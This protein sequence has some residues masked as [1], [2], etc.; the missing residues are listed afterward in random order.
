MSPSAAS[1]R[2]AAIGFAFSMIASAATFERVAAD[3][4][5]ARGIGAAPD[6]HLA[7]IALDEADGLERHAEPFV[8]QLGI[9]RRVSLA[10]RMRAGDDGDRAARIEAQIHALVEDAALLDVVGHGAAAQLA[11]PSRDF[12]LAR[13]EALPVADLEALVRGSRRIRRCRRSRTSASCKA[14]C[15]AGS[16]CAGE[17][18]PGPCRSGARHARSAAR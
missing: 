5:A 18:R 7:G 6:R 8:H 4:R 10:V 15:S 12:V 11:A 14:A 1:I 2:A 17:S 13:L 16:G 9:D 3:Q